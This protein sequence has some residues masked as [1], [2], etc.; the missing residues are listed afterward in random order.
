MYTA[1]VRPRLIGVDNS[2]NQDSITMYSPAKQNP[3]TNRIATQTGGLTKTECTSTALDAIEASP[4][5]T[6]M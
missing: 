3:K 2:I 1:R 6:R 4:A 5:K